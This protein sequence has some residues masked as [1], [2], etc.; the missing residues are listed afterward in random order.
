M[1]IHWCT[2]Y[3]SVEL[4]Y[5]HLCD[6]IIQ[7]YNKNHMMQAVYWGWEDSLPSK[8]LEFYAMLLE[9]GLKPLLLLFL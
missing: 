9:E 6:M 8:E 2:S 7:M 3:P 4:L 5:K 1:Q